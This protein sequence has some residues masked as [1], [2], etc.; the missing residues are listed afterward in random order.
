MELLLHNITVHS[1][2]HVDPRVPFRHLPEAQRRLEHSFASDIIVERWSLAS[3]ISVTRT[4]KLYDY[5]AHQ[6]VDFDG[7][8]TAPAVGERVQQAASA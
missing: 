5:E 1:A 7:R 2:H 4:C 8:P 6:W 3:F